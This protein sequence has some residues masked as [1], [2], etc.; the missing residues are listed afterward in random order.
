M[1]PIV[2]RPGSCTKASSASPT[3][4]PLQK[5]HEMLASS[6][7]RDMNAKAIAAFAHAPSQTEGHARAA[8]GAHGVALVLDGVRVHPVVARVHHVVVH[9]RAAKHEVLDPIAHFQQKV[10]LSSPRAPTPLSRPKG[11][12]LARL[13][14][15]AALRTSRAHWAA[16]M[17]FVDAMAGMMFFTTPCV[18]CRVTP[19][20]PKSSARDRAFSYTHIM[21]SGLSESKSPSAFC[22]SCSHSTSLAYSMQ[23]AGDRGVSA[24]VQS[25]KR[26]CGSGRGPS[27]ASGAG[28]SARDQMPARHPFLSGAG[29]VTWGGK[30]QR[31]HSKHGVTPGRSTRAWPLSPSLPPSMMGL[32]DVGTAW[33]CSSYCTPPYTGDT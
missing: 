4:A 15:V 16:M 13:N 23:C 8:D 2:R 25:G 20:M 32:M 24:M 14:M 28:T 5:Q 10:H 30:S 29:Q 33:P 9:T 22:R 11:P 18:S 3:V 31:V 6:E 17:A 27:R 21:C 26:S 12:T 1:T 7:M 19:E